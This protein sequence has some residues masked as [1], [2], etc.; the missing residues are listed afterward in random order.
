PA[1]RCMTVRASDQGQRNDFA[2]LLLARR[3]QGRAHRAGAAGRA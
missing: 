1:R 2:T 3:R